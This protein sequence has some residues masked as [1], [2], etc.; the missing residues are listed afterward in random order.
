MKM[1]KCPRCY[2]EVPEN[3]RKCWNCHSELTLS[4][5]KERF[6]LSKNFCPNCNFSNAPDFRFCGRCGSRLTKVCENCNFETVLETKFCGRCGAK[7]PETKKPQPPAEETQQLPPR[8]LVVDDEPFITKLIKNVLEIEKMKVFTANCVRDAL[9]IARKEKPSLIITD[10]MMPE[11]DGFMLIRELK[12]SPETK[13]IKIIML[14]V[15]DA[16]EEIKKSITLGVDEYI[17]KPFDTEELLWATK[18]LLG[19]YHKW[20]AKKPKDG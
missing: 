8:I 18:K 7:F 2:K 6:L 11:Q 19:I 14:T 4:D 15:V 20:E 3:S 5:D 12:K 10:L 17:S 9:E 16:F 13:E 1:L